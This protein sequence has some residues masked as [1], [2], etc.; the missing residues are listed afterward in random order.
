M[1]LSAAAMREHVRTVVLDR[2]GQ[3]SERRAE[4]LTE[5][6]SVTMGE[7]DP[8][9]VDRLAEMVPPILPELYEKWVEMFLDRFFETVPTEQMELL[10]DGTGDNNAAIILVYLMFLESERMEAQIDTDLRE[11]GLQ[12]TG[13]DDSGDLAATY[14]RAK[15]TQ[16]GKTLKGAGDD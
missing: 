7:A 14:I 9:A 3:E 11:Y 4:A 10:C 8:R 5:F 12:M 13:S 15:M 2:L 16:L 1:G 6:F